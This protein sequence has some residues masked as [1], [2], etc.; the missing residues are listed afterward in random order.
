MPTKKR[1]AD[2]P[3]KGM[4]TKKA[5]SVKGGQ[6]LKANMKLRRGVAGPGN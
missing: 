3:K 4:N 6:K 1:I 2:L 5:E